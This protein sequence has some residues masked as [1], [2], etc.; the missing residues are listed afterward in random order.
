MLNDN[1]RAQQQYKTFREHTASVKED[2]KNCNQGNT[3]T[4]QSETTGQYS[5]ENPGDEAGW[6]FCVAGEEPAPVDNLPASTNREVVAHEYQK[7]NAMPARPSARAFGAY[8]QAVPGA[9]RPEGIMPIREQGGDV[10]PQ[11]L[12]KTLVNTAINNDETKIK[13]VTGSNTPHGMPGIIVQ[14]A[15]Q[16][17]YELFWVPAGHM[18][19][20]DHGKGGLSTK[21]YSVDYDGWHEYDKPASLDSLVRVVG[22]TNAATDTYIPALEFGQPSQ[23][24]DTHTGHGAAS[25]YAG[26]VVAYMSSEVGGPIHPGYTDG[27]DKHLIATGPN[28]EKVTVAHVA[29]D[30][31]FYKDAVRDGALDFATDYPSGVSTSGDTFSEVK[32]GWSASADKW[33]WYAAID[34]QESSV[35]A[36]VRWDY[37]YS[38]D[39]SEAEIITYNNDTGEIT[40][41]GTVIWIDTIQSAQ[42][43][44]ETAGDETLFEV[45]KVQDDFAR[46]GTIRDLYRVTH[47]RKDGGSTITHMQVTDRTVGLHGRLLSYPPE[48]ILPPWNNPAGYIGTTINGMEQANFCTAR[49]A[50]QW[51]L[52]GPEDYKYLE[53]SDLGRGWPFYFRPVKPTM[54]NPSTLVYFSGELLGDEPIASYKLK[55][56]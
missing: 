34:S 28:G 55:N 8:G 42:I 45:K 36:R 25:F 4:D 47:C 23:D 17:S 44:F 33:K 9:G 49:I 10:D 50:K 13:S 26:T 56:E 29:T 48:A 51:D 32:L 18:L 52:D 1:D 43:Q 54:H 12:A 11:F 24:S 31:Y 20:A 16:D 39:E 41:A 2:W 3:V 5:R 15:N 27:S 40:D 30:A 35:L 14:A 53:L 19:V 37:Q 21:V 7:K 6:V 38:R 46:D 22:V